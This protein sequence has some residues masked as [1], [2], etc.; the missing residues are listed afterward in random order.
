MIEQWIKSKLPRSLFGRAMIIL[1]VPIVVIQIVVA[2]FFAERLFRD[3]SEQMT[4]NISLEINHIIDGINQS[5]SRVGAMAAIAE[6]A[7]PLR[8]N[9]ALP[10]SFLHSRDSWLWHDLSGRYVARSLRDN[11][12]ELVYVDLQTDRKLVQIGIQSDKGPIQMTFARARASATNPH[13]L[14]VAMIFTALLFTGISVLFLN[15]QIRPIKRLSDASEAFGRGWSIPFHPRGAREVRSAGHSFLAMR[16]RIIRQI[17]QR[18]LMLSGVSHDLRTP[19]TRMKLSLDLLDTSEE[20]EHLKRDVAE[21]EAMLTEFLDF[22]RGDSGEKTE[23]VGVKA[24]TERIVRNYARANEP[25]ELIFNGETSTDETLKCRERAVQRAIENLIGN[26]IRYGE[27]ARLTTVL[28]PK[29][30]SFI[31]EDAGPGIPKEKRADALE[32]FARLDIARNQNKGS[33]SGLGLAITADIAR[34]HGG[35]LEL[36][37]SQDLGGLKAVLSLPR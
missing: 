31:V 25:V 11:I 13:Q 16:A 4:S 17:E 30:V 29:N 18:T 37:H 24:L 28:S 10:P 12:P 6:N 33:G 32:P 2:A 36:M 35:K 14:L 5:S 34:S 27:K 22:A 21:M 26:A 23:T 20:V 15:N 9:V 1:A 8:I 3:V 7:K 19:L